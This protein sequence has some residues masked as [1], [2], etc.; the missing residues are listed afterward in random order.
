MN[1]PHL[2]SVLSTLWHGG[3]TSPDPGATAMDVGPTNDSEVPTNQEKNIKQTWKTIGKY[4]DMRQLA[5]FAGFYGKLKVD[6]H[7]RRNCTCFP[8]KTFIRN[9]ILLMVQRSGDHQSRE[10]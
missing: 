1:A 8:G 9:V 4:H 6:G 5:G 3:V 7:S 2:V 10:R